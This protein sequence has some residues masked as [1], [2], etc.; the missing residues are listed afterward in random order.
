MHDLPRNDSLSSLASP[1][2]E[3]KT[4]GVQRKKS[5]KILKLVCKSYKIFKIMLIF[6]DLI[7]FYDNL[8]P[9]IYLKMCFH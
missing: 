8:V 9:W 4:G 7:M 5:R 1:Y 3:C 2:I 6:H